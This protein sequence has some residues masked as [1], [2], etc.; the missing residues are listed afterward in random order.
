[1]L[2]K[3]DGSSGHVEHVATDANVI[4]PAYMCYVRYFCTMRQH[5]IIVL[6]VIGGCQ[7]AMM[8]CHIRGCHITH[9]KG[10]V[11]I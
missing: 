3:F 6:V 2:D 4:I 10:C 11:D 7:V 9:L 8:W 5:E 1:M